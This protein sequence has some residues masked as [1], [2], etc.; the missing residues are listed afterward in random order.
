MLYHKPFTE[1][2][3]SLASTSHGETSVYYSFYPCCHFSLEFRF[4]FIL[5]EKTLIHTLKKSPMQFASPTFYFTSQCVGGWDENLKRWWNCYK[6]CIWSQMHTS[7][8][9]GVFNSLP[10]WS[11]FLR[12]Y[13]FLSK[14][15]LLLWSCSIGASPTPPFP[16]L[17]HS[18]RCFYLDLIL[19][20]LPPVPMGETCLCPKPA[21]LGPA[22]CPCDKCPRE[23]N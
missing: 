19:Y 7:S 9:L 14:T 17:V 21:S 6:G 22:L 15:T 16:C 4:G 2:A 3:T 5:F 12:S 23:I 11:L 1:W 13:C 10:K 8:S 20:F 18:L